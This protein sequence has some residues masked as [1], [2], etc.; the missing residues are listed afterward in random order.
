MYE[1]ISR[2]YKYIIKNVKSSNFRLFFSRS[3]ALI[4]LADLDTNRWRNKTGA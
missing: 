3:S 4:T 1:M 2:E